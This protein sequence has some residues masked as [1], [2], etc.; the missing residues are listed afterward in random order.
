MLRKDFKQNHT[1]KNRKKE[2]NQTVKN[3]KVKN[4]VGKN[5]TINNNHLKYQ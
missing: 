2:T 3:K 1:I 4:Q 5:P